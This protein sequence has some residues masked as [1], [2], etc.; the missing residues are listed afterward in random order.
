MGTGPAARDDVEQ[1][2]GQGGGIFRRWSPGPGAAASMAL[3]EQIFSPARH[4]AHEEIQRQELVGP[5]AVVP[6]D[7]PDPIARGAQ[8]RPGTVGRFAG[9]IVLG[10]ARPA[11]PSG[12][13][14]PTEE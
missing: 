5:H 4:D 6:G 1:P 7:P 13:A 11:Q 8:G 9:R 10:S 2:E 12:P 14:Q 3:V